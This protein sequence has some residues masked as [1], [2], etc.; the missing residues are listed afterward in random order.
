MGS[1]RTGIMRIALILLRKAMDKKLAIT[2]QRSSRLL[3]EK[4]GGNQE[5]LDECFLLLKHLGIFS[6]VRVARGQMRMRTLSR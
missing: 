2:V 6:A 4:P 1:S 5:C 3:P